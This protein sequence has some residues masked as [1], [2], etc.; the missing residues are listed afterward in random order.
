MTQ[1]ISVITKEFVLL[2]SDRRLTYASGPRA[3]EIFNDDT[4]KLVSLCNVCGIGYTGLARICN[5]PTH[6][7][8]ATIL[9]SEKC[10]DPASA[11]RIISERATLEFSKVPEFIRHQTFLMTGWVKFNNLEGFR[12]FFCFI[13]NS[14]DNFGRVL[15]KAM[16]AFQC[17]IKVLSDT[18]SMLW[19][20]IGQPLTQ[21][22]ESRLE[23]S[24]RK[25]VVK[26][27]G[28]REA[29]RLLS[30]EIINTSTV[31]NNVT[32]GDKILGLC[33][34]RLSIERQLQ[35][36]QSTLLATQPILNSA[37]FTYFERGYSELRQYGPTFVCGDSI[38]TDTMTVNDPS[39]N[40]QSVAVRIIPR[41]PKKPKAPP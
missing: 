39:R 1:I 37:A 14:L 10:R 23:R 28:P 19:T 18:E 41:S 24:L 20:S 30:D 6:E 22:R 21:E 35:T 11:S 36:G 33:I 13:T 16:D 34:P 2:A 26:E 4:C 8:I 17:R 27:I 32:V 3:G 12:S 38:L 40:Y 9:A 7:W 5:K 15:P 29:L 25:L 31:A